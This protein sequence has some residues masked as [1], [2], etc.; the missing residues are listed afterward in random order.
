MH[1]RLLIRTSYQ[2]FI[3]LA[4]CWIILESRTLAYAQLLVIIKVYLIWRLGLPLH[5]WSSRCIHDS[6]W[7]FHRLS[8]LRLIAQYWLVFLALNIMPNVLIQTRAVI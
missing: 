6:W 5:R 8:A 2:N 4:T 1:L 3:I 7:I